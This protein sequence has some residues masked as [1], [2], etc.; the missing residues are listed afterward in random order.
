MS[1]HYTLA[2]D[3]I[4]RREA[5][6]TPCYAAAAIRAIKAEL[7]VARTQ[8]SLL[9]HASRRG[10][11]TRAVPFTPRE[12]AIILREHAKGGRWRG[13]VLL[14]LK[15]EC[16]TDRELYQISKRLSQLKSPKR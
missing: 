1:K 5:L 3:D 8:S 13:E 14:R 9:S 10:L 7:G 6:R 12:D 15:R 2:E 4:I 11:N 16:G